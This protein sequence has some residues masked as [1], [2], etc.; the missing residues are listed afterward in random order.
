MTQ[1]LLLLLLYYY[2]ITIYLFPDFYCA[3]LGYFVHIGVFT[4]LLGVAKYS[5]ASFVCICTGLYTVFIFFHLLPWGS[6][7]AD[8]GP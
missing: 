5:T 3:F 8:Q 6:R 7:H 4:G 2:I 1:L